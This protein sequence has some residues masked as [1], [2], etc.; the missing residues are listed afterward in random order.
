MLKLNDH[1]CLMVYRNLLYIN[2]CLKRHHRLFECLNKENSVRTS[3][4]SLS[5]RCLCFY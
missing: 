1:K 4:L 5:S 3:H 2:T